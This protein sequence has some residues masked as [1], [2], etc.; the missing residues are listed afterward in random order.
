MEQR[1]G[2][3]TETSRQTAEVLLAAAGLSPQADELEGLVGAYPF[4]R[5]GADALYKVGI[6]ETSPADTFELDTSGRDPAQIEP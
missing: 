5:E 6:G 2:N 4:V 1:D 3:T